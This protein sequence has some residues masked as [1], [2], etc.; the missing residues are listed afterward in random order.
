MAEVENMLAKIYQFSRIQLSLS[1]WEIAFVCL[2]DVLFVCLM[3]CFMFAV[4]LFACLLD[5]LMAPIS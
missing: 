3:F 5:C 1:F 4:C 2:F